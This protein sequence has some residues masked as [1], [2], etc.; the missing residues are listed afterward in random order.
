M[1]PP[2]SGKAVISA[3]FAPKDSLA[4]SA[5]S[6]S[7]D[8]I[9]IRYLSLFFSIIDRLFPPPGICF[10]GDRL[11]RKKENWEIIR[12]K[13]E[14]NLDIKK[15]SITSSDPNLYFIIMRLRFKIQF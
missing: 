9:F 10:W 13:L 8:V 4:H 3:S 2:E 7:I 15:Q 14:S 6:G 5:G 12:I 11:R 1:K